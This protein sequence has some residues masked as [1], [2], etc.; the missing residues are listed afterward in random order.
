VTG[1]REGDADPDAPIAN[2]LLQFDLYQP[3]GT[4]AAAGTLLLITAPELAAHP[5]TAFVGEHANAPTA[6]VDGNN[7]FDAD[8][9]SLKLLPNDKLQVTEFRGRLCDASDHQ[10]AHMRRVADEPD[11]AITELLAPAP[12]FSAS[13]F[14]CDGAVNAI[15]LNDFAI[16]YGLST[17]AAAPECRFNADFDLFV[18]QTINA[19][20]LNELSFSY[21]EEA[22]Q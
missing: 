3:D 1:A 10:Q 17:S 11:P 12:C 20:D 16:R 7:F 13:D 6:I 18:D 4:T 8:G 14:N 21:G 5:L 19:L 15:D 9:E 22:G 2:D